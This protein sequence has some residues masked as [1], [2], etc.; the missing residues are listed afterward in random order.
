MY[1]YAYIHK[2]VYVCLCIYM[3]MYVDIHIYVK[4]H[5]PVRLLG[6]RHHALL[7]ILDSCFY[8][9]LKSNVSWEWGILFL[10]FSFLAQVMHVEQMFSLI[11]NFGSLRVRY[12]SLA[13]KKKP[14]L[15]LV[16]QHKL[17]PLCPLKLWH[18]ITKDGDPEHRMCAAQKQ[19]CW[20]K[21]TLKLCKFHHQMEACRA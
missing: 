13:W 21:N 16:P 12:H 19:T 2:H 7:W 14:C 3:F 17:H 18:I 8:K 6:N 4:N 15:I 20:F 11:P 10:L 5:G 9:L 1:L